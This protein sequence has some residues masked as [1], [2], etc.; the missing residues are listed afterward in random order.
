MGLFDFWGRGDSLSRKGTTKTGHAA[1]PAGLPDITIEKGPLELP[2][3]GLDWCRI[4]LVNNPDRV[5]S[6]TPKNTYQIEHNWPDGEIVNVCANGARRA[7][8]K[9]WVGYIPASDAKVLNRIVHSHGTT[10]VHAKVLAK[11]GGY[12]VWLLVGSEVLPLSTAFRLKD[13]PREVVKTRAQKLAELKQVAITH[14]EL[15]KYGPWRTRDTES[16]DRAR[17]ITDSCPR[18][19]KPVFLAYRK[20]GRFYAWLHQ[21]RSLGSACGITRVEPDCAK[22]LILAAIPEQHKKKSTRVSNRKANAASE[23][24]VEGKK[25]ICVET[26]EIFQSINKAASSIGRDAK[27]IRSCCTGS[28]QTCGGLH[29]RFF[30]EYE[31]STRPE[32]LSHRS[33]AEQPVAI[34]CVETGKSYES[35]A[36][37]AKD[38][39]LSKGDGIAR[40]CKLL[41]DT[42]GGYHWRYSG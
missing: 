35:Y 4:H 5:F 10:L 29:W 22:Q 23:I 7:T 28:A 30:D 33:A 16:W 25:V 24:V 26:G 32:M 31:S 38:V 14:D 8:G 19:G 17:Y 3:E 12:K 1:R 34:I 15:R 36:D 20:S 27:G 42:A 41:Q 11:A 13:V 2:V 6:L 37:A 9:N 18:C 21:D 40:C 39:G